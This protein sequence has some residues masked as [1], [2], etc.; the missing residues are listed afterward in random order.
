MAFQIYETSGGKI[1]RTAKPASCPAANKHQKDQAV[2]GC[3]AFGPSCFRGVK[4][5]NWAAKSQKAR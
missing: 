3:P 4:L 5:M 1:E 2:S